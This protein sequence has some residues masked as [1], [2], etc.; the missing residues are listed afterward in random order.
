MTALQ[1]APAPAKGAK[2][3]KWQAPIIVRRTKSRLT[4]QTQHETQDST[5]RTFSV[6][7]VD[8]AAA[9]PPMV[10]CPTRRLLKAHFRA[11]C[12]D[13]RPMSGPEPETPMATVKTT[14]PKFPTD[15]AAKTLETFAHAGQEQVKEQMERTMAAVSEMGA[16]GKE[17][18]EAWIASATAAS[19]GFE[20]LSAHYVAYSKKAMETNMAAAKSIMSSKSIQ[21]LMERQA[22]YAKTSFEAYVAEL[23]KMSELMSGVT[24]DAMKP[25]NERFAAVGTI[26]QT[27]GR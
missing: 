6:W 18:V 25:L 1:W 13:P 10:C 22:D 4:S 9:Q 11:S 27:T 15:D 17:N 3:S 24:K 26:M 2:L 23:N 7:L 5:K 8:S 14:K 12:T 21:E 20:A 16:F 19:K